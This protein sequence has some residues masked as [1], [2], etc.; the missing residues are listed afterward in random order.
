MKITQA[1]ILSAGLGTRLAPFTQATAKPLLPI[2]G[3]S[4]LETL[5]AQ[6]SDF[7]IKKIV[8]NVHAHPEHIQEKRL[9]LQ[10]QYPHIQFLISNESALLMGSA[11]GLK[12]ALKFFELDAPLLVLNADTLCDIDLE[13]LSARHAEQKTHLTLYCIKKPTSLEAYSQMLLDPSHRFLLK[14]GQ[15]QAGGILFSGVYVANP[16]IFLTLPKNAASELIPC[17][18]EPLIKKRQVGVLVSQ[19]FWEDMG[20]AIFWQQAHFKLMAHLE[21]GKPS[22]FKALFSQDNQKIGPMIWTSKNLDMGSLKITGPV[23][24]N[25]KETI[26]SSASSACFG[27]FYVGYGPVHHQPHHAIR[28]GGISVYFTAT[29]S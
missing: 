26:F 14:I 1:I 29:P 17:I 25:C 22:K 5:V 2:F 3:I 7:G 4:V 11:G 15:K 21:F 10:T 28:W 13:A 8:F 6:L 27:P 9:F 12:K 19:N 20:S 24:L 23:Y 16:Q 18:L